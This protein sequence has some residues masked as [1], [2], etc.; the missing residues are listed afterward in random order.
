MNERSLWPT[1]KDLA[2]TTD[3]LYL[4][5]IPIVLVPFE[6]YTGCV[7]ISNNFL[8]PGVTYKSLSARAKIYH[9]GRHHVHVSGSSRT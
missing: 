2:T 9:P 8:M 3:P 4:I 5:M 7:L 1:P 6:G